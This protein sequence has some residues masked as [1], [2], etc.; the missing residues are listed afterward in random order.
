MRRFSF[1]YSLLSL[2]IAF[3]GLSAFNTAQAAQPKEWTFL[4]FLN[5]NNSLDSFGEM[6]L[7]QM[8]TI[9]STN[10]INIVVQWASL[11]THKIER[12]LVQKSSDG[13]K[14]TSP[15]VEEVDGTDMG[16]YTSVV[17]F[18]KWGAA[19]YPAKHY[20]LDIWDHGSGWHSLAGGNT[21]K[22]MDISLDEVTGHM[23]TTQQLGLALQGSAQAI[24]QKVDV[25]ASDACLMAMAEIGDEMADSVAIYAGSQETEPGAGWPYDAFLKRWTAA[26]TS[27][28]ADVAKMLSEE[29]A[30]LYQSNGQGENVTF[31]AWD[32]S[33]LDA[34][35]QSIVAFVNGMKSMTPATAK[36]VI[37]AVKKSQ[38]FTDDDYVDLLDFLKNMSVGS[39][40]GVN[41]AMISDMATAT[42]NMILTSNNVSYP[43]ATGLSIWLPRDSGTLNQYEAQY[44]EL[45][46]DNE[47]HW[48]DFLKT[49]L[50]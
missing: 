27:S 37:A 21:L 3:T 22:P 15:V 26:P 4:V 24:G 13:S 41:Q 16:V 32:L 33:K 49:L 50:K 48:S 29:Y 19:N 12:L 44:S 9:G 31:S 38:T 7:K 18:V 1:I 20:F 36:K 10:D 25:Y 23:I 45:K 43:K 14:V 47:T 5:G 17:D 34:F 8:E 39:M 30:K 2:S 28:P 42:K 11:S 6:N 46:F 40:S 35:K